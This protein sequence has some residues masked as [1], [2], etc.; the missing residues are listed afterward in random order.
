MLEKNWASIEDFATL[1][2]Y[3]WYRDFPI[4]Q[5]A[6]GAKRVDWTRHIDIVVRNVADL[7]GFVTRFERRGRKDA[8]LR[9]TAGDEIAIEWEWEDIL[10]N[11]CEL[12]G[13]ELNKL[14]SYK[15]KDSKRILKYAVLITYTLADVEEVYSQIRNKW[16]E[17]KCPLLLILI[18]F[19]KT[20]KSKF[21]SLREFKDIHIAIFSESAKGD[22]FRIAP[23]LPWKILG[24]RWSHLIGKND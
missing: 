17:T 1:F 23:A 16:K 14:K 8:V 22:E 7:V 2:Q 12:K 15:V 4:D 24:T 9:S 6:I 11:K 10:G 18:D 19:E 5:V 3:F 20:K 13:N 21:S